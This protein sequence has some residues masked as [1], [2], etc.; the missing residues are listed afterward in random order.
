MEPEPGEIF[1]CSERNGGWIGQIVYRQ[2]PQQVHSK[3]GNIFQHLR[4]MDRSVHYHSNQVYKYLSKYDYTLKLKFW[5]SGD[6]E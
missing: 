6:C 4:D 5:P 3:Y 1:I 2:V